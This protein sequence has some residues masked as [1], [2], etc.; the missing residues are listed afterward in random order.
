MK[1]IEI[2]LGYMRNAARMLAAAGR[3]GLIPNKPW[4]DVL[5]GALKDE[6]AVLTCTRETT[7]LLTEELKEY[8]N[9][10]LG[11]AAR[12]FVK[13]VR[14]DDMQAII[15]LDSLLGS[16]AIAYCASLADEHLE[17]VLKA[18]ALNKWGDPWRG[19]KKD[20]SIDG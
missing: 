19:Q 5:M 2:N 1:V 20:A 12:Q 17:N 16:F 9:G 8:N 13:A 10:D 18:A 11:E 15:R 7:Y 3:Q 6:D 14:D 4:A